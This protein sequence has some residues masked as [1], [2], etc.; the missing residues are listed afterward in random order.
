MRLK[1]LLLTCV[2]ACGCISAS[3]GLNITTTE[4]GTL[5]TLVDEP[6]TVTTLTIVGPIDASDF[7]FIGK[8][9]QKLTS[10]DLSASVIEPYKGMLV[11][12]RESYPEGCIPFA[13]LGGMPLTSFVF[14]AEQTIVV[15]DGAFAGTSLTSLTIP[16]NVDSIGMG[17]FAGCTSLETLSLP[18]SKL[19]PAVFTDCTGLT[20]VDLEGA[21]ALPEAIFR[22]C[23]SL[24]AVKG[25]VNLVTIGDKAFEGDKALA[26]FEFGPNLRY[27]GANAFAGTGITEVTL[28]SSAAL[29]EIGE[30]VFADAKISTVA[31]SDKVTTIGNGALFGNSGL[32]AIELPNNLIKLG[33]HS[34]TGTSLDELH[35]PVSLEEIGDYAL[36]GQTQIKT[37]VLPPALVYIGSHAMDGMTGLELID[38]S[39]LTTVPDLGDEVW[40]GIDQKAVTLTVGE[41]YGDDYRNAPQWQDFTL[42]IP[43]RV[44]DIYGDKSE[45][46]GVRGRFAGTNLQIESDNQTIEIVRVYDTAGRLLVAVEPHTL[47]LTVDTSAYPGGIFVVGVV[48][49]DNTQA[50][51]KLARR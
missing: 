48:L 13:S 12:G 22:G 46:S 39:A 21:T 10:L 24:A 43:D 40:S 11:N 32:T 3:Y 34:L 31:L 35:L 29:K 49:Q 27:I 42:N 23:T 7:Y 14:P 28:T 5:S 37:L 51:L 30:Q 8:E 16:T 36:A 44:D 41:G 20:E 25:T 47:T 6:K 26:S 9:M 1:T 38:V 18:T 19:G 15:G 17:A 33:D 45:P 50:T 2:S 4:A